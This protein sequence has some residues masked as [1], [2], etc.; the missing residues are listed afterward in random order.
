MDILVKVSLPTGAI[1]RRARVINESMSICNTRLDLIKKLLKRA[2]PTNTHKQSQQTILYI[3]H[4][5]SSSKNT[6]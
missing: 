5:C 1:I 6:I 2:Y 4:K 3:Q